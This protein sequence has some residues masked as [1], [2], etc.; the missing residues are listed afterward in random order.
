MGSSTTTSSDGSRS[1]K[2]NNRMNRHV[3]SSASP[4]PQQDS[5]TSCAQPQLETRQHLL[6]VPISLSMQSAKQQN[7]RSERMPLSMST[8]GSILSIDGSWFMT[9]RVC[10]KYLLASS[11]VPFSSQSASRFAKTG[12]SFVEFSTQPHVNEGAAL[13]NSYAHSNQSFVNLRFRRTLHIICKSFIPHFHW[14]WLKIA[15]ILLIAQKLFRQKSFSN[16][17]HFTR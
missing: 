3:C 2:S 13:R 9:E 16:N 14:L 17:L 6:D 15:G 4:R 12:T 7:H 5:C 1:S 11:T 10:V 8:N